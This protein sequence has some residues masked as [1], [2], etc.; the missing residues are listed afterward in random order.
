MHRDS[1]ER[2]RRAMEL[3]EKMTHP[4]KVE[5]GCYF[6][7]LADFRSKVK[8][9]HGESKIAREYLLIAD[10]MGLHFKDVERENGETV[11]GM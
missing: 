8:E 7:N 11:Q 10:L 2:R 6:G 9:T 4:S 5:C 3:S 1:K